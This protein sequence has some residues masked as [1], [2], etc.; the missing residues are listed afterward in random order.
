MD[1]I[2]YII[3]AVGALLTLIC[4]VKA[5]KALKYFAISSA[6]GV[7]LLV[8]L[9]IFGGF[10]NINLPINPTTAVLSLTGGLPATLFAVLLIMLI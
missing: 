8:I 1:I 5:G 6:S 10:F 3:F 7:I 9:N 2:F 4:S